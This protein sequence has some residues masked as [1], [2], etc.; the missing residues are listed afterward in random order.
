[1][2][3][4]ARSPRRAVCPPVVGVA[5]GSLVFAFAS[6][7][8]GG[9]ST[10]AHGTDAPADRGAAVDSAIAAPDSTPVTRDSTSAE[11]AAAVIREYYA[12]I[13]ARDYPRAY[14]LWSSDGAASGRTYEKFANGFAHTARVEARIGEPGRI[15][16]AAGSRY[17]EVPVRLHAVTDRGED[18][19]FIGRFT[20]R[21]SEVDGATAEQRRWR[22]ASAKLKASR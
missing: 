16:A 17:I 8:G 19:R 18:Q 20:L 7:C 1:M 3:A 5:V 10:G 14:R 6:G 9:G 4:L 13:D 2:H 21:R 15:D 12:A 22:I 11:A